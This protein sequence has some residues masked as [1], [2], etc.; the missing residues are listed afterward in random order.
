MGRAEQ[1]PPDG[2]STRLSLGCCWDL[3]TCLF[4]TLSHNAVFGRLCYLF[5]LQVI[6]C[7][8]SSAW[9]GDAGEGREGQ[10]D[11]EALG[12]LIF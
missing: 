10:K 9:S 12:F 2:A 5:R 1:L 3:C 11:L 8:L 4:A 7:G 6:Y